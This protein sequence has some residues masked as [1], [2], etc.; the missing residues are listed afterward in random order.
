VL[1]SGLAPAVLARIDGSDIAYAKLGAPEPRVAGHLGIARAG[2]WVDRRVVA[3]AGRAHLYA[4]Y[5]PREVT[6]LVR[7]SAATGARTIVLTNAAGGLNASFAAGDVMIAS[8]H[9]NL[10][11]ES[12]IDHD[13]PEPFV[14]MRD[15]YDP[16]VRAIAG[17]TTLDGGTLR[18]GVYAGLRG[19]QYETPAESEMLRRLGADAVG[20][21]TVLETIAARRLGLAVLGLSLITNV[22]SADRDVSHADVLAAST[23]GSERIAHVIEHMLLKMDAPA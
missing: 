4:G 13:D 16:H 3:F 8:D 21:S 22:I 19:P 6:Y 17:T 10:T 18:A 20:M 2:M 11:G 9:L 23:E 7:L 15:A 12:P 5:S 14:N 1:G